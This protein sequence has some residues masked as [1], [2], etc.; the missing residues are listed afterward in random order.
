MSETL[1]YPAETYKLN[2][3][4]SALGRFAVFEPDLRTLRQASEILDCAIESLIESDAPPVPHT[5]PY[6]LD[7]AAKFDERLIK[8]AKDGAAS[9]YISSSQKKAIDEIVGG[10]HEFCCEAIS[11]NASWEMLSNPQAIADSY[12]LPELFV[13]PQNEVDVE[14]NRWGSDTQH[15][16]VVLPLRSKV[17]AKET[18]QLMDF[19]WNK[20]IDI[21]PSQ[22]IEIYLSNRPE[23]YHVYWAPTAKGLDY[24][25]PSDYDRATQLSFDVPHNSAHLAHLDAL[26]ELSGA[27]RYDDNM[28]DRAYFEAVA[29][30]S[31]YVCANMA[32]YDE[33][34]GKDLSEVYGLDP[35]EWA[36]KIGSWVVQDRAYEFKL[37]AVRYASDVMMI[38]GAPLDEVSVE[39]SKMFH[40]PKEHAKKEA[41]KYLPWTG[42][43]ATYTHGYRKL[44]KH[45]ISRI[46]DA[47]YERD[48]KVKTN[49]Y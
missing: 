33:D 49:W 6:L 37:R 42:L 36:S 11:G 5:N 14:I 15:P 18:S 22:H 23:D 24:A 28:P 31:E 25:T 19:I 27:H 21:K 34:F 38:Q 7:E 48:G 30:L 10:H 26:G 16:E 35:N 20:V 8:Q 17:S 3:L 43:G 9:N 2:V 13:N 1:H 47:I 29:V 40:I 44:M 41:L 45:G 4:A 39:L 12:G 46:R 32:E